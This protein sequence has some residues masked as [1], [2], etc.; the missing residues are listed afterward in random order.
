MLK[1]K[2]EIDGETNV[3]VRTGS[4]DYEG[5]PATGEQAKHG[6]SKAV[7]HFKGADQAGIDLR[8]YD[9]WYDNT[10]LE[11]LAKTLRETQRHL[12]KVV[13]HDPTAPKTSFANQLE[14]LQVL[15]SALNRKAALFISKEPGA[16]VNHYLF[17]LLYGNKLILLNPVGVSKHQ[18]LY[19]ALGEVKEQ[20]LVEELYLSRTMIQQEEQLVSC[21]PISAELMLHYGAL[22]E[23]RLE[24]EVSKLCSV[25]QEQEKMI[26]KGQEVRTVSYQE[27]EVS[28]WLPASLRGLVQEESGSKASYEERVAQLRQSQLARL[29]QVPS[30]LEEELA[31]QVLFTQLVVED[32]GILALADSE[33]YKQLAKREQKAKFKFTSGGEERQRRRKQSARGHDVYRAPE[34][35][36]VCG[37]DVDIEAALAD[38]KKKPDGYAK[39][40]IHVQSPYVYLG[41][42]GLKGGGDSAGEASGS[43]EP[44]GDLPTGV[45]EGASG[46]GQSQALAA[47]QDHDA[48]LADTFSTLFMITTQL[49]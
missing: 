17:G 15:K 26:R 47:S 4:D 48:S 3:I 46:S 27:V 9:S 38:L 31:E 11:Y 25:G 6:P 40:R 10:T 20:G 34:L 42:Q 13:F 12:L 5:Y 14:Q 24:E 22:D 28:Q 49:E 43:S 35:P 19:E 23:E 37:R 29:E 32:K 33:S 1:D 7:Q 30:E 16:G 21:G 45:H 18:D 44:Q 39:Q 41:E 36:V 8:K 2:V